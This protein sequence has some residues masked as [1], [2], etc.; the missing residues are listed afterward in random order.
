ME[1]LEFATTM[2]KICASHLTCESCELDKIPGKCNLTVS[3]SNLETLFE[4]VARWE[5]DHK[6]D[7][8]PSDIDELK[9]KRVILENRF[10]EVIGKIEELIDDAGECQFGLCD[11]TRKAARESYDR[12]KQLIENYNS[13]MDET[14]VGL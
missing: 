14:E 2:R 11:S 7:V 1:A 9:G 6:Y 10:T 5:E 12:A 3:R 13:M 8:T 4:I